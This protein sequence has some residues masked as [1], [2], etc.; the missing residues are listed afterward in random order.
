MA[1][2]QNKTCLSILRSII[3]PVSGGEARFAKTIG[4]SRSWVKKASAGIIPISED[5]AVRIS[6]E[7]GVS[8]SWLFAN[9][10]TADPVCLTEDI[11]PW[12][13]D[14]ANYRDHPAARASAI[15]PEHGRQTQGKLFT[16]EAY[17]ERR[18]NLQNGLKQRG[19]KEL[20]P[21]EIYLLLE[22]AIHAEKQNRLPLFSFKLHEFLGSLEHQFGPPDAEEAAV[23]RLAGNV[24]KYANILADLR[25]QKKETA[26][27]EKPAPQNKQLSQRSKRAGG[28]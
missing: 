7:T 3:G 12:N 8:H 27:E 16:R 4:R 24:D 22:H 18:A 19:T 6:H 21:G 14:P 11:G 9:D 10:P 13:L 20:L 5:A 2:S 26:S 23:I 1:K 28:R 25:D 17:D 15:G